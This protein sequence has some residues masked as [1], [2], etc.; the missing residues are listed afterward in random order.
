MINVVGHG[1]PALY[2]PHKVVLEQTVSIRRMVQ[3]HMLIRIQVLKLMD[4]QDSVASRYN[5][6]NG[7]GETFNFD[8]PL[9]KEPWGP[10]EQSSDEDEEE[11]P[12][13]W[14]RTLPSSINVFGPWCVN[15]AGQACCQAEVMVKYEIEAFAYNGD[16]VVGSTSQEVRIYD[17]PDSHPPPVH[18]ADFA[19]EYTCTQEKRLKKMCIPGS[20][21]TVTVTEPKPVEIKPY[22]EISMAAFPIRFMMR[23]SKS[24][25]ASPGKLNVHINSLLKST[26][27]IAVR[28]LKSQPTTKQARSSPYL[29]AVPKYGRSYNRTLRICHWTRGHTPHSSLENLWVAS[30][31]VWLPITE[32]SNPAPTFF[33]KY[34]SR[35][36]TVS[37]RLDVRGSGK[38]IFNLQVPLQLVYPMELGSADVPSYEIATTPPNEEEETC[39]REDERLPVYVR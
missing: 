23:Q 26:T 37:L 5:P 29:A 25:L 27:F 39:D 32:N 38:G 3:M 19:E 20:R 18:V 21:L 8:F 34:L 1:C 10:E 11:V 2:Q 24:E 30:A 13:N 14:P 12:Q 22:G 15:A 35:R 6:N 16:D 17:S 9:N 33:T 7:D 4:V 31:L 36:Y 28:Q